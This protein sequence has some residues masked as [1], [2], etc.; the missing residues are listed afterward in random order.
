MDATS[1]NGDVSAWDVSS[2]TD[3][4]N[5]FLGA[6]SFDQLLCN[7]EW[8]AANENPNVKKRK[9]F[10]K[11]NDASICVAT[12]DGRSMQNETTGVTTV[13]TSAPTGTLL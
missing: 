11:T 3:M 9:M 10:F 5:M 8:I 13:T 2:V 7:T 1:F 6:I 4:S 12:P